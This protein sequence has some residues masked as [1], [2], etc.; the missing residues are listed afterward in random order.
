MP[1]V[2][3]APPATAD[4]IPPP[5]SPAP[6]APEDLYRR[7]RGRILRSQSQRA[8]EEAARLRALAESLPWDAPDRWDAPVGPP[9][10]GAPRGGVPGLGPAPPGRPGLTPAP[11][12]PPSRLRSNEEEIRRLREEIDR[13]QRELARVRPAKEPI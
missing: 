3:L 12:L 2:P 4:S 5:A 10:E 9:P 8:A 7:A 13:L 11:P 1:A 6:P